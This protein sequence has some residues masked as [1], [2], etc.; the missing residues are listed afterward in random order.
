M[1]YTPHVL[2]AMGGHWLSDPEE[3]WECTVRL[4]A[5]G[6]GGDTLDCD[7]YLAAIATPLKTW[8]SAAGTGM[9]GF[10][11]LEWIKA[12]HIGTDGKYVDTG[13]THIRD[14]TPV[15]SGGGV[16]VAPG[17]CTLAYTWETAVARGPGHRGRIYPPNA[18]RALSGQFKVSNADA[19][20]NSLNGAGLLA[21]LKNTAAGVAGTHGTPVVASKIGGAIH[22]IT[23]C[24][25]DNIYDVQRRRKNRIKGTRSA[26]AAFA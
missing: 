4:S 12:N 15:V 25:S 20:A 22:E 26:V 23:G 9:V 8:Y 24:S 14:Y 1:A 16:G 10:A 18:T 2:F 3:I 17:Y 13:V 19:T 21:V 6:G 11:N 7:A 5:D